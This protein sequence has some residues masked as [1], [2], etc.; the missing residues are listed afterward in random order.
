MR[1]RN[2]VMA[3]LLAAALLTTAVTP[4]VAGRCGRRA[5][6][7]EH[8]MGMMTRVQFTSEQEEQMAKVRE[9]YDEQRVEKHNRLGVLATELDDIMQADEPDFGSIEKKIEEMSSVRLELQK[10]RLRQHKEIR[11]LLDDDQRMLF[12]RNFAAR[13]GHFGMMGDR[14][15]GAGRPNMRG[16]MGQGMCPMGRMAPGSGAGQTIMRGQAR[17]GMSGWQVMEPAPLGD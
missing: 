8:G 16:G 6:G 12:D 2:L 11:S 13:M 7:P 14:A 1:R 9:K 10:I 5:K 3:S 4:A 17:G 15:P